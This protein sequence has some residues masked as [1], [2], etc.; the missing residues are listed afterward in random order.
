MNMIITIVAGVLVGIILMALNA[1]KGRFP[2]AKKPFI[3]VSYQGCGKHLAVVIC[4]R[5]NAPAQYFTA[6]ITSKNG[7]FSIMETDAPFELVA[8]GDGGSWM[9]ISARNI[10]PQQYGAVELRVDSPVLDLDPPRMQSDSR[11]KFIGTIISTW[12]P[13]GISKT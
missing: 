12:G 7:I 8:P 9:T 10:L 13:E 4:N 5:G 2:F 1:Q 3:V 11:T 6:D